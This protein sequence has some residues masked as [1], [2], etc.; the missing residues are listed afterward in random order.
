MSVR[1]KKSNERILLDKPTNL[2][3]RANNTKDARKICPFK[4]SS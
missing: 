2:V 3:V 1:K 4:T